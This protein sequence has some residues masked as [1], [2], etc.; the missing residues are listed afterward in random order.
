M[1]QNILDKLA[2]IYSNPEEC[3]ELLDLKYIRDSEKGFG[4]E[5]SGKH[6]KYLN[7][8]GAVIK[9]EKIIE[10]INKLRIPPAWKDVW[11]A[12]NSNYYLQAIGIDKKGKKQYIYHTKWNEFRGLLKFY[13]LIIVGLSLPAIREK[14]E[15]FLRQDGIYKNKVLSAVIKIID[16]TY[17]RIGNDQ[18]AKENESFG[19]TTLH[20]KHVKVRGKDV[21]LH[22]IG[23]SGQEQN[24]EFEDKHLA[25]IL[26]K[27]ID[28]P[29]EDL[30]QYEDEKGNVV[31]VKSN[32]VNDFLKEISGHQITAKDFRTWGGTRLCFEELQSYEPDLN[33]TEIKI[34]LSCVIETVSAQLGNTKAV[35]KS[36]YIHPKIL[37]TF[38][39]HE[40]SEVV[41]DAEKKAKH[42]SMRHVDETEIMLLEFLKRF[43]K[44]ELQELI[45]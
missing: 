27:L 8:K 28:L 41:R 21:K 36:H 30:F 37:S 7:K 25:K 20:D 15:K 39:E 23:K 34:A 38:R 19:I 5:K 35:C 11:I 1:N 45:S 44:N 2:E 9:T 26:K 22:F 43:F 42:K 29:G 10:R 24:I 17:I 3:A 32:D 16:E 14:I 40:F 33:K 18:Y 12:P 4:R 6:F 31:D 13:K